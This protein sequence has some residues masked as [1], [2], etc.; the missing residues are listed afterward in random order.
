MQGDR[1]VDRGERFVEPSSGMQRLAE[2]PTRHSAPRT[3][4]GGLMASTRIS[5]ASS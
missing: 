4:L 2:E 1:F 5:I 3:G